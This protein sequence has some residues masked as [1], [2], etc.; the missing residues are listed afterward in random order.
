MCVGCPNIGAESLINPDAQSPWYWFSD[1]HALLQGILCIL[2]CDLVAVGL[3]KSE[4]V[5]DLVGAVCDMSG[6]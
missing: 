2:V 1:G 6:L 4:K 5:P 3:V